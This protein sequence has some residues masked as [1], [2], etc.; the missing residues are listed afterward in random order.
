M[1]R[2]KRT[3]I[4]ITIAV[5]L[6]AVASLGMYRVVSAHAGQRGRAPSRPSTSSWRSI[7]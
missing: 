6:A 3:A 2:N 5:L 1:D 7:R 4:V